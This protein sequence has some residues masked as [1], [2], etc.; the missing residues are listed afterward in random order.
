M[1]AR[2]LT[3]SA[4]SVVSQRT[5]VSLIRLLFGTLELSQP[6]EVAFEVA[7][8]AAPP[9]QLLSLLH[10]AGGVLLLAAGELRWL[11][12]SVSS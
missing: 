10:S 1:A 3:S 8:A 12:V 5:A 11:T 4:D 6:Q 9:A 7:A 2:A